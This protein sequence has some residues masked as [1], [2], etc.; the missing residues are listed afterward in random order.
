[1]EVLFMINILL[2]DKGRIFSQGLS[3]ILNQEPDMTVIDTAMNVAGIKA[4]IMEP[5]IILVNTQIENVH[6]N[7]LT[8]T[9]I[10]AFPKSKI[11]YVLPFVDKDKIIQGIESGVDGFI[12]DEH[13]PDN[14]VNIIREVYR[15]QHV[16]SGEIAKIMM[17]EIHVRH[18]DEKEMLK[19]KLNDR[20]KNVT[21]RDLDVLY[22]IY[23]K[24]DNKEIADILNLSK[25]TIRDYVSM[26]YKRIDINNRSQV[27]QF[28]NELMKD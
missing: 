4:G 14:F 24:K 27:T 20:N 15:G 23:K 25:K 13:E 16:I 3:L 19:Q 11:I 5:D 9:L 18:L 22:L 10:E 17:N 6:M 2:V 12:L 1:M 28:L 8:F 7:R 26:A 21:K